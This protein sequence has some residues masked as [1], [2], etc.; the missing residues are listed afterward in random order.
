M[1]NVLKIILKPFFS[2]FLCLCFLCFSGSRS[3][4]SLFVTRQ[5]EEEVRQ[6]PADVWPKPV[7]AC[8][9]WTGEWAEPRPTRQQRVVGVAGHSE[10]HAHIYN[11][12]LC[13]IILTLCSVG[14]VRGHRP[15]FR[16]QQ[17]QLQRGVRGG[18]GR[19]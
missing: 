7:L 19:F 11:L 13:V 1:F 12:L 5:E 9:W 8:D 17:R 10:S 18:V 3:R 15:G 2:L 6:L 4:K 16:L 14:E